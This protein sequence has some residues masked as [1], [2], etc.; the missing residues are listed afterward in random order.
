MLVVFSCKKNTAT[1]KPKG[2][3]QFDFPVQ[4]SL[5]Q[6]ELPVCDFNFSY[7]NYVIIEQ[8]S[9]F[10]NEKPDHPCW[11]NIQYKML[12]GTVHVSYKPLSKNT[13]TELTEDYHRMK[14]EHVSKADYIDEAQIQN[15]E[16]QLYGLLS[17]VGGNVASAYQF[18]ITDSTEHFVRGSLYF[19]AEANADSLQPAVE[20]VKKDV[21]NMLNSWEWK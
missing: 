19:K 6:F 5:Q 10:F 7:P 4:D 14:Y 18:Y 20:F 12:N 8:D 17:E 1:P 3:Y 11:L 16:K 15:T 13:I 9:L 21:L 2:Y